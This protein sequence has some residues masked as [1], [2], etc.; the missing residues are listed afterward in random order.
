MQT[1]VIFDFCDTLIRGQSTSLFFKYIHKNHSNF[2]IKVLE[3]IRIM[4]KKFHLLNK[5][6][7]KRFQVFQLK[8]LLLSDIDVDF[9][10]ESEI[11]PLFRLEMLEKLK[12]HLESNHKV[13]ILSGGY[14][15]YLNLLKKKFGFHE[16]ICSDLELV[17][18]RF[19][20]KIVGL[21]CMGQNKINKLN[22]Q[23]DLSDF[24]LTNSFTYTDDVSDLPILNLVGN[25]YI[26][27]FGQN[28]SWITESDII[29]IN[30]V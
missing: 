18:G 15:V 24:D 6:A 10:F 2:R 22:S 30:V 26:V 9:F 27:N 12:F 8:G 5:E 19:T 29:K 11:L 7:H 13:I 14:N 3:F 16:I 20:G 23:I 25:K 21:D 4:F 1:L 17:N 28:L